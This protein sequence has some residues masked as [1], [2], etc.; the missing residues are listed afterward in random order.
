[1]SASIPF[2][3]DEVNHYY[4]KSEGDMVLSAT[5]DGRFN[6]LILL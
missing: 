1:L 5:F 3:L 6:E 4:S 2:V